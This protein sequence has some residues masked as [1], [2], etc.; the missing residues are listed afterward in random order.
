MYFYKSQSINIKK[1]KNIMN[2]FLI[3]NS[4]NK[5]IQNLINEYCLMHDEKSPMAL[6]VNSN[7]L[8]LYDRSTPQKKPIKV[9]FTSEKNNYRCLNFKKKNEILYKAI[10]IKNNYFPFVLD[11]TAGFGQDSFLLSFLGCYVVMIEH[12]PVVSALLK[13]GLDRGYKD[14]K[15][16]YWLKQRFHF[17]F[18][19]SLNMMNLSISKPDV[20]YLDP[21]YPTYT[22]KSLPK[23]NMQF[24]RKLISTNSQSKDLLNI[25]R[26][27]AR[28][29][30]VVKRPSYA[31][32]ISDE[33]VD[34]VIKNKYHRFDIYLPF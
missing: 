16:G 3:I 10:G 29:R 20:I 7:S 22:K 19:D 31:S 11:V 2:I 13:D 24:L 28:N 32:P 34:F 18:N 23:K 26:K 8:E 30:I 21:M 25:S 12:H 9:D 14:Q 1:M 4:K 33:R 15:I 6:I 27:F 17:L 5:R